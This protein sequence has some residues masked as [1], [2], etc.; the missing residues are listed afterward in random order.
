MTE[1]FSKNKNRLEIAVRG[2]SLLRPTVAKRG[3]GPTVPFS[4]A[5]FFRFLA[6]T[7]I[8]FQPSRIQL[9]PRS[10]E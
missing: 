2:V 6:A 9:A 4:P 10:H 1:F 7:T 5:N 8:K 3:A